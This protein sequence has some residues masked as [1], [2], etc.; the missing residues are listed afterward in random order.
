[1]P[2]TLRA[3]WSPMKRAKHMDRVLSAQ[4]G[5]AATGVHGETRGDVFPRASTG[6]DMAP[7]RDGQTAGMP[8]SRRS[9]LASAGTL[10]A[11]GG[12]GAAPSPLAVCTLGDSILDCGRYNAHGVRGGQPAVPARLAAHAA[13]GPAAAL[14]TVAATTCC[15][16]WPPTSWYTQTIEPSLRGF[17]VE[18]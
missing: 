12:G 10:A 7:P 5:P 1:M 4:S 16:G 13:A 15:G 9:F 8:P 11:G 14:L 2:R 18:P 3:R 17:R 6:A